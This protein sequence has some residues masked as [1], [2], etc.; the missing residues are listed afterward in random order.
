MKLLNA[1]RAGQVLADLKLD[2]LVATT[3]ENFYYVTELD[4]PLLD[5]TKS[6]RAAVLISPSASLGS[7][8]LPRVSAGYAMASAPA[9]STIHLYGELPVQHGTAPTKDEQA[10]LSLLE[11]PGR[12]APGFD[13]ALARA[14]AELGLGGARIGFDDPLVADA[15]SSL[16]KGIV[17][18]DG[19]RVLR[20]I[21]FV[22]T[23]EEIRRTGAAAAAAE[24][25]EAALISKMNVDSSWRDVTEAYRSEVIEQ[26]ATPG[27]VSGGAGRA[28]A[29]NTPPDDQPMQP[30]DIVR[31]DLGLAREHYWA[32]TGRTISIGPASRELQHRYGALREGMEAMLAATRPGISLGALYDIGTSTVQ[33]SLPQFRRQHCGHVIGLR[34]Y[35]GE[36]VTPG[37]DTTL[38][39]GVV[40]NLE[41]PYLEVGWGGMQLEDTIVVTATG[42]SPLTRLSRDLHIR[43]G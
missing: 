34:Q 29:F 33:R 26:E 7:I 23:E 11:D 37:N 3:P 28:S 15:V 5:S 31:I 10:L 39:T 6:A 8:V 25:V 35:D 42:F 18:V 22:K 13:E 12:N 41:V 1:E 21:R 17:A 27:F 38:E 43:D 2:A 30:G 20:T 19:D 16:V 36:R 40:I 24:S 4:H 9:S 14:I 32:D